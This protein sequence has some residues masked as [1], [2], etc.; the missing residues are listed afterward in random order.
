MISITLALL[1]FLLGLF[2]PI[3]FGKW[4]SPV[5]RLRRGAALIDPLTVT[6][7]PASRLTV[8]VLRE[9]EKCGDQVVVAHHLADWSW[10]LQRK[11]F[12]MLVLN[13][14]GSAFLI[15]T[16]IVMKT[17][18]LQHMKFSWEF[19]ETLA[20]SWPFSLLIAF[21][22]LEMVVFVKLVSDQAAKYRKVIEA[23]EKKTTLEVTN[24]Q[25]I[26][27]EGD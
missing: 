20:E 19:F 15:M 17:P 23:A 14:V 11:I 8:S 26:E 1:S 10:E 5:R 4:L 9:H 16:F 25:V 21:S 7:P 2:A 3:W 6:T 13:G 22:F 18:S 27:G 24:D 12:H